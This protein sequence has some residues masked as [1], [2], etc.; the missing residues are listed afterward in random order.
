MFQ[1]YDLRCD[2]FYNEKY[3]KSEKER[4][5]DLFVA[6][7]VHPFGKDILQAVSA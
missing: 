7:L 1:E 6:D 5:T 4:K 2:V 3:Q